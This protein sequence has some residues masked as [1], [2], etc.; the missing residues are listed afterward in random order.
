MEINNPL[1][2]K[3]FYHRCLLPY[4]VNGADLC[5]PVLSE[6][7]HSLPPQDYQTLTALN[8]SIVNLNKLLSEDDER[9]GT[10][11]DEARMRRHE[12]LLDTT[13]IP[14]EYKVKL[15]EDLLTGIEKYGD[16]PQ[17]FRSVL[18]KKIK[19]IAKGNDR[20]LNYAAFQTMQH[21]YDMSET[22]KRKMLS[23]IFQKMKRKKMFMY[24][25]EAENIKKELNQ[26]KKEA[27]FIKNQAAMNII[28]KQLQKAG[29]SFSEKEQLLHKK[30]EICG[31]CGFTRRKN[32]SIKSQV[33]NELK[34]LYAM[35]NDYDKQAMFAE[36]EKYWNW[37]ISNTIS[38]AKRREQIKA[39][40]SR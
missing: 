32:F 27:A 13:P 11:E 9:D 12:Y 22:E 24:A 34:N 3:Y 29:L 6:L 2:E 5:A 18:R 10:P 40:F 21:R 7:S 23:T 20:E 30:L 31:K 17:W 38:Y 1:I 36:Q 35:N 15:Y 25:D 37:M 8:S 16:N 14:D 39:Q 26:Q 28:N 4:D 33:C 19:H